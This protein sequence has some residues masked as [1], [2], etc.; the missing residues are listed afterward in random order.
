MATIIG[1]KTVESVAGY[2]FFENFTTD[3]R[4]F[5]ITTVKG[6]SV[7]YAASEMSWLY[8]KLQTVYGSDINGVEHVEIASES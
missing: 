2:A 4:P 3:K 6:R 1:K 5:F 7:F 8:G